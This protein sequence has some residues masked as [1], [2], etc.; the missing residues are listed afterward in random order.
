MIKIKKISKYTIYGIKHQND[1][2]PYNLVLRELFKLS[3]DSILTRSILQ[4]EILGMTYIKGIKL[5]FL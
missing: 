2:R 3:E 5:W 4:L 1:L